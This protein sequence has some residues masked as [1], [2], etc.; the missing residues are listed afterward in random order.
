[1]K[2]PGLLARSAA[3]RA[4]VDQLPRIARADANVLLTGETGTGKDALALAI[5]AAS[6]RRS[7]PFVK[8]DCASLPQNLVESELFG[9]ERG[10]FTDATIARAGRFEAAGRGTVYLDSVADLPIDSQAKL[11]RLVEDKHAERLGGTTSYPLQARVIASSDV[12]LEARVRRGEFREDLYHRL[13]VLPLDLPPLRERRADI[14]PLARVF[15]REAA[16]RLDRPRLTLTPGAAS[17]LERHTWPG[18]VREL[19]HVAERVVLSIEPERTEVVER[20]L[21][22]ELFERADTL[23]AEDAG[24]PPTLDELERRYIDV[25]LR[26]VKD[27]QGDAAR[28]LG[29]S[30]KAL[31]EKRKR[32][33]LR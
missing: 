16:A 27:N 11:L 29:I 31:W 8:I 26:R 19:R 12:G 2:T 4:V 33:G 23:Y 1:M 3:M 22:I 32:Y 21:P 10:A 30:R 25:V 9:H 20:D 6:P 15:L 13:R 14:L 7:H 28:I 24:G 5:H 18:N 17:A